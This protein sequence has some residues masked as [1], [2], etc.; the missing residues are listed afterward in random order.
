MKV[1]KR[2]EITGE[3]LRRARLSEKRGDWRPNVSQPI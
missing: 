3:K 1:N 2:E